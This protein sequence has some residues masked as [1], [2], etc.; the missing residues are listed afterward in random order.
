MAHYITI[1][2][3]KSTVETT[4]TE[5]ILTDGSIVYSIQF[6][7]GS[8]TVQIDCVDK[9]SAVCLQDALLRYALD[10]KVLRL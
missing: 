7:E 4:L 6:V 9:L 8:Q 3:R 5:E 10:A 1:F 2:I